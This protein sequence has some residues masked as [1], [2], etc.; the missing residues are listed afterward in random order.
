MPGVAVRAAHQRMGR[1]DVSW[2]R[3]PVPE[4]TGAVTVFDVA[5][6]GAMVEWVAGHAEAVRAW[7]AAVW[8]A[9]AS[10]HVAVAALANRLPG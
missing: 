4:H 9:W 2:P 1:P 8:Q 6:A 10:Q 7:A 5:A 3:L